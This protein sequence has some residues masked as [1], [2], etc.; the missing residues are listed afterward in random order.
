MEA[1]DKYAF[2]QE[3]DYI[4][5]DMLELQERLV[6]GGYID[7]EE[8][9]NYL[10]NEPFEKRMNRAAKVFYDYVVNFAPE[11]LSPQHD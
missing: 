3:N 9:L 5:Y 1:S 6:R 7:H 8:A 11:V 10:T 4:R 2:L